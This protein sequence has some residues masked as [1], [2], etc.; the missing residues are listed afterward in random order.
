MDLKGEPKRLHC[1]VEIS[2][3]IPLVRRG[4][5]LALYEVCLC[6]QVQMAVPVKSAK[7]P[8]EYLWYT[9]QDNVEIYLHRRVQPIC[10]FTFRG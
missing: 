9:V 6:E 7:L 2:S 5:I 8:Y 4:L 10:E 3:M 1:R